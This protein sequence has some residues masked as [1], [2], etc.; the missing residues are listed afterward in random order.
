MLKDTWQEIGRLESIFLE[1]VDDPRKKEVLLYPICYCQLVRKENAFEVD[2]AK[3]LSCANK[4]FHTLRGR[5]QDVLLELDL[6]QFITPRGEVLWGKDVL[7]LQSAEGIKISF[8]PE[9]REIFYEVYARLLKYW[10]VLSKISS[11]SKRNTPAE[12]V[13]LSAV[14]FNEELYAELIH[15]TRLQA[16]R[17]P[18]EEPFF[19][20]IADLSEFYIKINERREFDTG[21]L[22]KALSRLSDF[23]SPYYGI[24]I[25]KLRRDVEALLKDVTKGRK[26]FILKISFTIASDHGRG[27]VR[28]LISKVVGKIREIGGRRWSLMNSGTVFSSFTG[29][30]WRRQRERQIPV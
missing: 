1:I 28:R 16:Q 12:A 7:R 25:D 29:T 11:Y 6:F 4:T 3:L 17:F 13:H 30:S 18:Q 19:S 26:Y 22:E 9:F 20:V 10:T 15:Y 2:L 21:L 27:M 14:I 8:L 24:N 5:W 23:K